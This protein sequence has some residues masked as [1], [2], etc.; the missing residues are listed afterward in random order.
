MYNTTAARNQAN[1]ESLYL[2]AGIH[3][4]VK[5]SKVRFD[6]SPYGTYFIELTFQKD[7][8]IFTHTEFEPKRF[9]NQTDEAYQ[10]RCNRQLGRILQVLECY[11]SKAALTLDV[12]SFDELATWEQQKAQDVIDENGVT[13]VPVRIKIV[14]NK[15]GFKQFPDYCKYK[16]IEPMSVETSDIKKEDTDMFEKPVIADKE[17]VVKDTPKTEGTTEATSGSNASG[18]PF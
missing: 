17:E 16:F 14:Y 11:Y 2:S 7:G 18:L 8:S 3:D 9:P 10:A 13:N 15:K 5:L 1:N 4:D 6:K 12:N